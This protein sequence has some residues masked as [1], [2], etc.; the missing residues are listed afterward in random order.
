MP[1]FSFSTE[2]K[3]REQKAILE[4]LHDHGNVKIENLEKDGTYVL[5]P[6]TT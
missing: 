5:R 3:F 2:E 1:I 6:T 4:T